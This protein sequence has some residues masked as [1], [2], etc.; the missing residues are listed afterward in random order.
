M[1]R[2]HKAHSRLMRVFMGDQLSSTVVESMGMR[3]SS[4]ALC[5]VVDR[6]YKAVGIQ[7]NGKYSLG[8]TKLTCFDACLPLPP[9]PPP[10]LLQG[11]LLK[12]GFQVASLWL[13]GDSVLVNTVDR[14]GGVQALSL[15]ENNPFHITDR[16]LVVLVRGGGEM[17]TQAH[18]VA[19]ARHMQRHRHGHMQLHTR[20]HAHKHACTHAHAHPSTHTHARSRTLTHTYTHARTT[21][22]S[23]LLPPL[24]PACLSP[25]R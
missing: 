8:T 23:A 4:C 5:V 24:A 20:T 19:Q 9:P 17:G 22:K 15:P 6:R 13:D 12:V 7:S 2:S 18:A 1:L 10:L 16:P 11:G 21:T 25:H 14:F 3:V